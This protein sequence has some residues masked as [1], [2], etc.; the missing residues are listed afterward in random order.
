M[1]ICKH[2]VHYQSI[3]GQGYFCTRIATK[4]IGPITGRVSWSLMFDCE[5]ER[6]KKFSPAGRECCGPDAKFYK[7][8][9]WRFWE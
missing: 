2:C 7:P 5:F 9:F 8:K 6:T 3:Q 1:K 4:Q